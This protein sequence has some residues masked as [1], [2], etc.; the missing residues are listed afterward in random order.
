MNI[1]DN[2]VEMISVDKFK[3]GKK[4][5]WIGIVIAF[6]HALAGLIYGIVLLLEKNHRR[7]GIIIVAFAIAWA[8]LS[9]FV[10][11][12]WLLDWMA[13]KGLLIPRLNIQQTQFPQQL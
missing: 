13:A 4:W 7:E 2:Q 3:L 5:F 6:I 11:G 9:Y 10:V 8:L 12:P 1:T